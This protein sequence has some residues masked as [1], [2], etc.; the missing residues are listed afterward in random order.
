MKNSK[1]RRFYKLYA[2]FVCALSVL[3]ILTACSNPV[4]EKWWGNKETTP[5]VT[6]EDRTYHVVN[7]NVAG[8]DP[9]VE[10]QLVAH[11]S[12]ISKVPVVSRDN[13]GFAGW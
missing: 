9:F 7:F 1:T 10:A 6:P 5:T 11:N 12:T 2:G 3:L 4:I 8:G 13:Y